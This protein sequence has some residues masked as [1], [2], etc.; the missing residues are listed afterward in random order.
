MVVGGSG[1]P[2]F[3]RSGSPAAVGSCGFLAWL[4]CPVGRAAPSRVFPL[5]RDMFTATVAHLILE[6]L[7]G[8]HPQLSASIQ[9]LVCGVH[10]HLV[11]ARSLVS[12]FH[13]VRN[14]YVG[15]A[16]WRNYPPQ[17]TE[18]VAIMKVFERVMQLPFTSEFQDVQDLLL[19]AIEVGLLPASLDL[20][21]LLFGQ[22]PLQDVPTWISCG[23]VVRRLIHQLNVLITALGEYRRPTYAGR[24]ATPLVLQRVLSSLFVLVE[25]AFRHNRWQL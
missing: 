13:R 17:G 25:L 24:M 4:L 19:P 21:A 20:G 15:A 18:R 3:P 14:L 10:G 7:S 23:E 11:L 12:F 5:S 9:H 22:T 16:R 2:L 8:A 1:R 6:F